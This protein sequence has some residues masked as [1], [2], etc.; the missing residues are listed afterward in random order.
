MTEVE[1]RVRPVIRYA[2]TRFLK[3]EKLP[4]G[5]GQHGQSSELLGEFDSEIYAEEVAEALRAQEK[6]PQ[7]YV[8]VEQTFETPTH[9]VY[10]DT[11]A[12]AEKFMADE[13]AANPAKGWH[14]FGR[15][16]KDYLAIAR[17]VLG[18]K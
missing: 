18:S 10:F 8:V 16:M 12:D 2:V 15:E 6:K 13:L 3:W 11:E 7:Q 14:M 4:P 17:P 1:I 9:A 5:C